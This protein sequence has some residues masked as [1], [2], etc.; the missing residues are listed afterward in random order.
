LSGEKVRADRYPFT[1]GTGNSLN[2]LL[3]V[4]TLTPNI[5]YLNKIEWIIRNT[6]SPSDDVTSRA[7][8]NA[9]QHWSYTVF[10]QALGKYLDLKQELDQ[11][12][13][14][15]GYARDSLLHYATWMLQNEYP[16]LNKPETLEFPTETWPA[17]DMKKCN[18]FYYAA[19]Y[20]N[21]SL[22]DEFFHKASYFFN[23]SVNKTNTFDTRNLVRPIA[24]MLLDGGMHSQFQKNCG[25]STSQRT[26]KTGYDSR[27]E[28][29]S[30]SVVVSRTLGDLFSS[31]KRTSLKK[32]FAW[33]VQ[34]IGSL[35]VP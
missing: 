17:A 35:R 26:Q 30:L 1:R 9:E 8:L 11:K 34:K 18:V 10:L 3:D 19:K 31:V 20:S 23:Y 32:E 14:M 22:K 28:F 12:D 33:V 2:T 7:L 24:L 27:E 16:Y 15:Y 13:V 29:I 5:S 25:T 4:Y 6:I 21:G